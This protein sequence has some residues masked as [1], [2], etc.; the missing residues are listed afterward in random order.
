MLEIPSLNAKNQL[1]PYLLFLPQDPQA[2]DEFIRVILA[3]RLARNI[4]LSFDEE[5]KVYQRDLIHNLPHSN[6]SILKYLEK[7]GHFGLIT[8]NTAVRGGKRVVYHELTDEGQGIASFFFKEL[9]SDL[10]DLTASLLENYLLRLVTLYRN[11]GMS[12]FAIFD[13]FTRTRGLVIHDGSISH[14]R[15]D[16][17]LFGA[18]AFY[19]E[20]DCNEIPNSGGVASCSMPIRYP[21]GP[22]VELALALAKEGR[23]VTFVSVVGNDQYGYNVI[24]DLVQ[25]GVDVTQIEVIDNRRTNETLIIHDNQG[26]RFLIGYSDNSVLSLSSLKQIPW[27]ILSNSKVIYIGEVFV[28]IALSIATEGSSLSIPVVYQP[29]IPFLEM[30]L[31]VLEPI[32]RQTDLLILSQQAWEHV[33][34]KID[35]PVNHLLN[36]VKGSIIARISRS[37]YSLISKLEKQH[38]RQ[39]KSQTDDISQLFVAEI[40]NGII[41]E[42]DI[43]ESFD[44]AIELENSRSIL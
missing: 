22:S 15:P 40:L 33:T 41:E 30:G 16:V 26:S 3:S 31:E 9:P 17:A 37:K 34:R 1:W 43:H 6:K 44:K 7:L 4:F 11:Q 28:E 35:D 8:T 42:L 19:S 2:R 25:K 24:S 23:K 27:T 14:E 18:S 32:I 12:E 21:G 5:G 20:I 10:G 13:V 38:I 29:S 39:C 36:L